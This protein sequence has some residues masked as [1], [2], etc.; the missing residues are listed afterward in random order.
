M[1]LGVDNISI[2]HGAT[3]LSVF[4]RNQ[5]ARAIEHNQMFLAL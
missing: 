3:F 2:T 1:S 5:V 4:D